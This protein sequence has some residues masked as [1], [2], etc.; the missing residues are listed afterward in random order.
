MAGLFDDLESGAKTGGSAGGG[1]F[2]DLLAPKSEGIVDTLKEGAKSTGRAVGAAVNT[3]TGN[4]QGI[5][6]KALAQQ[7]APKDPRLQ[8]FMQDYSERTAALGD[9]PGVLE[10]IGQGFGAVA[11]NPAGAGLAVVEQLPNAAVALGGGW[12][13][14]KA[15]AA[16]GGALGAAAAGIGAVPGA[17]AGGIIGGIAGMFLGNAALETG[18]KAMGFADDGEVTPEEMSQAK[19]EGAIKGGVI[20]GVDVLTLGIGGKVSSVMQRPTAAAMEA[21]S[22][23]VLID[24]G[25]DVT[26]EAAVLAATKNPTIATAVR[27]AQDNARKA[28][29]KL[30]KRAAVAGTL[31]TMETVGEG[32]GE[33]LGELAATGEGNVPDAVLEGL[34]GLGQSGAEAAWNMARTAPG[35]MVQPSPSA[36]NPAPAPVPAPDPAAGPISRTAAQLPG[37]SI[38]GLLP[39]P[40]QTLYGDA[41]GNL[42]PD[43]QPR[44]VDREYRPTGRERGPQTFGPGM[45]QS[46]PMG[47]PA[48]LEGQL[49][50]G[51]IGAQS[52]AAQRTPNTF[53]NEPS[54]GL[55]APGRAIPD[56]R[57]DNIAVAPDGTAVPGKTPSTPP[58]PYIQ[59]GPGM[60]QQR[61][62]GKTY[63]GLPAAN[64]AIRESVNPD[65]L[66]AV[67]VGPQ[68]FEVRAKQKPAKRVV[69]RDRDSVMQAVIR[70]GGVKT[71][72][73][74]DTTGD[75]KGNKFLPGVGAL[76]SDKT[77]TSLDDMA[78]LLDQSGYVPAGEM[79]RDGGV[80]WLQ[81]ALR[82]EVGGMKTHAAPGSKLQE[83]L[84]IKA[85]ADRLEA[86]AVA[87][88]EEDPDLEARID[89]AFDLN[90]DAAELERRRLASEAWIA[91]LDELFG[92]TPNEQ[93]QPQAGGSA[94][95]DTREAGGPAAGAEPGAGSRDSEQGSGAEAPG[96]TAA[97]GPTETPEVA[98]DDF[99]LQTQTE[100]ELAAADAA[101]KA[102]IKAE[103]KAQAEADEK[104]RK[105]EDRAQI[106]AQSEAQADNFTLGVS[107]EDALSG[108]T[109]MFD[110]QPSL[111]ELGGK[112]AATETPKSEAAPV[113]WFTTRAKAE[114]HLG[115]KRKRET[116]EIV[117]VSP[118]RFEI[119]EKAKSE[120]VAPAAKPATAAPEK[121][122]AS[123]NTI[124]TDE[125]ADE[126]R[127]FIRS[128]LNGSQLNSGVDPRLF[129]AGITLAGYHIE[130]G[131]RTFAAFAKAMLADMGDGV[132]PYLKQWYM[133]V[134]YDPR[135]A[136]LDGMSGAA[137]VDAFNL[138]DITAEA[139]STAATPA[140]AAEPAKSLADHFYQRLT[141]GSLPKDNRELRKLVSDFDGAEADNARLKEA[142]ED[143]EA[144][145]ARRAAD[146]AGKNM[147]DAAT[148]RQLLDLYSA[149]PNLNIRTSSSIENQ[150]YSTP[151][152]LA[153]LAARL[154][155]VDRS[156][157]VY[158]PTAGN[159]MLLLTADPKKA[160][161]N[162]LQDHR[163]ANLTARGFNTI[164]GDALEAL[165]SGALPAKSQDAVIT[166]P[167]FGSVKDD[168]GKPIKVS[169]DGYKI[170]QIDHLIVAE[171]LKAMKDNGKAVL[172]IGANKVQGGVST[173]DRIF[174]NWLYGN[175]NVTSHF[176]VDG[177]LYAR[178]GASWPVRV[179]SINGRAKSSR[180]SPVSGTIQR[181]NTWESV[182]EQ[183][184]EALGAQERGAESVGSAG[185]AVQQPAGNDART[186][187][188]VAGGQGTQA[189]QGS[190]GGASAASDGNVAGAPAG[191]VRNQPAS[192]AS[193][194]AAAT[195]GKRHD[196]GGAESNQ[197]DGR[198]QRQAD[199]QPSS[200]KSVAGTDAGKPAGSPVAD[201]ENSFQTAYVPRSSRKDEGVLVPVNMAD[202]LQNALSALE[203]QVGNIDQFAMRELGYQSVEALHDALMGLQ[204]DS[205]ASAINQIKEN[206]KGIIIADQTG[207]GKG[208]QAAA[209][210]R[211]AARNGYTPVFVTVKPQLFTDM[212][213]DLADIGTN[214]IEPF[215]M[216]SNAA[217]SSPAGDKL[218]ANKASA[219][220]RNLSSIAATGELPDERN[221]LFMTYSQINTENNQR[222][223]LSALAPNAI[224]ILDESHNAS[225]DSKTG[226]YMTS[227]LAQAKGV[228][229]LSATY[230]KRPD[231]MPL[232]F[233]TD[234]GQAISDSSSLI[235]AMAS[236]GLPLQTVI[237]NNLVKA[238]QMFRRERSY[239]GVSISTIVDTESREAHEALSDSVTEALRAIVDADRMFHS[240]TVA[241]M[242]EDAEAA[243][244]A[245]FDNAGNQA[246]ES[247][248]HTQFSSVVHNFVRQM[249]LGLKAN[250]AADRAIEALRR[251]EKPLIALENT[252]GSFLSEYAANN[253]LKQ[254][255]S[256]GD[257]TYR[258]VLSRAL[259]RTLYVIRQDG[260]G[261]K[262]REEVPLSAL[263]PSVRAMYDKAQDIIDRLDINIPVSPL[264][265]IR[266]RIADA[267][268][269]VAEITGRSITVD[270]SKGEPTLSALSAAEQQDKVGT[271]RKFN[272]GE[273]DAIILNVAG[274]T[275]ISLHASE[276]FKDQRK[277][278]MIVAQPAQDIN[279]FMQMLGRVHRTGQVVVPGYELLNVDL[280]TEKRPTALLNGKMKS[281]N[282]NTSSNTESATSIKAADMLNK[283]GDQVIASYLLDN[284]DLMLALDVA[285]KID[286]N[287]KPMDGFARTVTGRMALMPIQVQKD[288][289]AEV[290]EQYATLMEYLNATNQNDLEPRTFDFEA[291]LK[292]D[293]VLVAA[294]DPRTPFGEEA[295]YGEWQIKA[296]GKQMT[297][298]EIRAEMAENLGGKSAGEHAAELSAAA[299]KAYWEGYNEL[300]KAGRVE[301][302]KTVDVAEATAR[303]P[304][305]AGN[306]AVTGGNYFFRQH[307]IGT[308]WR[309]EINGD[310]Y[311]ATITN[312]RNSHKKSGNPFSLSKIQVTLAVNGPLRSLTVPASQ[313]K[314]IEIAPIYGVSI[315]NAYRDQVDGSE[316]AKIITGNLLAAYGEIKDTTGTI[317]SFTKQDGTTEQGILLPKR[318]D[319][320]A[321]TR[322]DYQFRSAA[323]ALKFLNAST[324]PNLARFGIASR[325]GDVRVRPS[326][327][328]I[329]IAVPKSKARGGRYFLDKRLIAITGD[330]VSSNDGMVATVSRNKA[331][332]A[333]NYLM[334]KA[335]LYAL[336]SMAEEA[337]SV[338]GLPPVGGKVESPR[339][340][341]TAGRADQ[342]FVS[343]PTASDYGYET[344]LFGNPVPAPR[345]RAKAARSA[346]AG[347]R[348]DV[349]PASTLSGT[350]TPAGR[351]HVKTIVGT[352]VS[353][354]LGTDRINSFAD[355]AQATQYLY[356]S[357]VERFDGVVTD[358]DG[359]P[360][361][362]VGGFKG[363]ID[364][365][366]VPLAPVIAEAVRVRGAANIWLSHNHPSGV[367]TLSPADRNLHRAFEDA[368]DGSGIEVRGLIAVGRGEYGATD[369]TSG[370]VPAE[371][372]TVSVPVIER[373][374][375][376]EPL[377]VTIESPEAARLV[378]AEYYEEAGRPGMILLDSK[379][380]VTGWAPF[381]PSMTA[382]PLRNTGGLN[383]LYRAVSEGN[384]AAAILVHGGE[385][386]AK[387]SGDHD[388]GM[389]IGA[390]LNKA[391]VR[392][393][394]VVNPKTRHSR[395]QA[396]E[397]IIGRA[398][399]RLSD[400]KTKGIPLFSARAI[401]KKVMAA[402][403]LNA[404]VVNTEADLPA[405]LQAQIK[406]D[407]ATGRVAGVYHNGTAYLVASNL[408]DTKHAISVMLHEA[409]GHG[410]VKSVLG[411]RIG[412]V[413][414]G[415]Y[416][417]MPAAI[418]KELERRYASQI[419]NLS[420][421][422]ANVLIAEEYVAHLAET[423]PQHSVI[424]RLVALLRR[425]IR[426]TFGKSAALKWTRNDLV[427][428]LAEARTA[429]RNGGR[430]PGGAARM[431]ETAAADALAALPEVDAADE[432]AFV[433]SLK[434]DAATRSFANALY[435]A[436]GTES[437]FFKA[438][439]GKS[440]MVDKQGQPIAFVHRSYGERDTFTD[441][442]LGKNTGTP[443]ASLGHF[444]ARKDVGNVERYGPVVEQ[445]YIRMEKPKVITQAQFEAMGDWSLTK[446]QA[447]RKTLMEQG[448]DGL[449]I[450]GLAWPVVFE[451]KN[452][453]ARRNA[454][455]FN[456]TDSARYNLDQQAVER[457]FAETAKAAGGEAAY[458]AAKA[459][460]RTK[461][462]YRQWV[463][464]RT[465]AFKAW[466][467]E[468]EHGT[469][470]GGAGIAGGSGQRGDIRRGAGAAAQAD[471]GVP[472]DTE[473]LRR[474]DSRVRRLDGRGRADSARG[475]HAAPG[476]EA[477]GPVARDWR[478]NPQTGEPAVFHHGTRDAFTAFDLNHPN[479]KDF[480]WL[481]RGAY[482]AGDRR[483]A[484]AYA[485]LK[486]GSGQPRVMDL[487]A[488]VRN[489]FIGGLDTKQE[490]R[491]ANP[492][493][494]DAFT[495]RL[496]AKGH[497][498]VV[499]ELPDGTLELMAFD[500]ANVKSATGNSG[501]FDPSN[502]DIR[503]SLN[504][505]ADT[506]EA[507]R[508]LGLGGRDAD[509]IIE[510]I[511]NMTLGGLKAKLGEWSTRSEEGIFD[512]LAGIKRAEEAVGVTDA[513]SQGYVSARMATGIA[514]VMH[515]VLHYAAPEWRD[516]VI[517]GKANTRGVLEILGDLGQD[518]LTP[519]LAWLGGKRAQMLKAQ[520]RENNLTDAD[521]AE[522]LAMGEG[523][524]ELFEKVYRDYAKTN[525]AVLDLA[526]GAGLIDKEARAKWATEYYVPFYR[527][528]EAEGI[529]TAPRTKRG[530]SHQ[531]AAIKALKGGTLPTNDL[532]TNML[533][534][535]T[536]R[537]D[538]A[539][540]NKALLEVV[541]NLKG[542]E[543]LSD[544]SPRFQ[545]VLIS[546]SQIAQQIRKDRKALAMAADMLG[547]P[548][549]S[550]FLKV[551]NQL[552]KPENEGFEKLWTKVAPTDPDIIRVQRGGK[553]E[554]YR[555]NDESLLR[556]LKFMEGSVF[557]DP[558]TRVGRTF[559]RLLTTGVTAS[560]D[561]ILRNF[562]R[563]AAHAWMINKDGFVLG[564]DSIKGMRD[565][566]REDQDYRDLMFAG[567]SF[568]GGYVHGTDPE[569]SAQII[570]R[571]LEKKGFSKQQQDSY[572]GS[573]VNTPAKAAAMLGRGWQSYRTLGDKVENANRLSTYKAALAAGK[574]KRQAAF[575]AKDLMDYSLRGNFA[576]AQWFTDVVPFLNA[577]LQG[578]YKL[579]RAVK[580]D[581]TLLAKEVAMKGAYIALFSLLLAGIN[582]DDERYQKLMDWDKD[583][584]WHIFLGDQHFRIPKPFE[585]GLIFGTIPERLL[586]ALTGTQDGGD[587]AKAVSNGVFQT[588]AFN[589]VPQFYQPIRELQANRNFFRD[590]PIEDMSDEGKLPEARFDERTSAAGKLLG[591]LTGPTLGISPKQ[592]DHLVQGYTGTLGGY[593]LGMSNLVAGAF[594]DAARPSARAGDLPVVKVLYQGDDVRSTKYQSEFY[595]MMREADQLHR[596]IKAYREEGR[597]DA[598]AQLL[599]SSRDKLRHRAALGMARQQ[600]GAVRKQM[601]AVY[602]DTSMSGEAKRAKLD[603]L[604]VRAN[605]IAERIVSRAG[606]DF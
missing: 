594:D 306:A 316:K 541:D 173:D 54:L 123:S 272:S 81:Q 172:I 332:E 374:Q 271:T 517:A 393:L 578:L 454:G 285:S 475:S 165:A 224:V 217:I 430:G 533:T 484:E 53:D 292:K 131:A 502:P 196:D 509:G 138:A 256:L 211:W 310:V 451:G 251:G 259:A 248:D 377:A 301:G 383:A 158:E 585:L 525:E 3:Y 339:G 317:I 28:T 389:N 602:R 14:M 305:A 453:K 187:Q 79:E 386:D 553:N 350:P 282:A 307:A 107:G 176:E 510:Q 111:S 240:V 218:F 160:T 60:D 183:Y 16:A 432:S 220:K 399:Y 546:R 459:A 337:H 468:W 66:E 550:K 404:T 554:Y 167:P 241:S 253:E 55:P 118:T 433:A 103:E 83:A 604:Q 545:Q 51:G 552:M 265:W 171:S 59:G 57:G 593:V 395:A 523:K 579:G 52:Q 78:S 105:E 530:L 94:D 179:I 309:V 544:E 524:E 449:Y 419:E 65:Q 549:G 206:G 276:K 125:A 394:D 559:K 362:V 364:S 382:G 300:V 164:Q 130:K 561:F 528:D 489:P 17:A 247:V 159:G 565:A 214:D 242:Q 353:R 202:P 296:Q 68:T 500:P 477:E 108:Q 589:P 244:E 442:D 324:D 97:A 129:Q 41:A 456:E 93:G 299:L 140:P 8:K 257:F 148:F 534:G 128:M 61:E 576:A 478:L 102:R 571:A 31:L 601:D 370:S 343:E 329:A 341:Y 318:F 391:G 574:S 112:P 471:A 116:H 27:T 414:A 473:S 527:Q 405:D 514:D 21:A 519:W 175:Y 467:G 121:P 469:E 542:S 427:L 67:K 400:G 71:E 262:V 492:E 408:R 555:V 294:T 474:S 511:R 169:V 485:K 535:W 441:A 286:S 603:Q 269:S 1:M 126:A 547:L 479:R 420:E 425:F 375:V 136:E 7:Q 188:A 261:N 496:R 482:L 249:L 355:L 497:D 221:A 570:R 338:L 347:V 378:A 48:P 447:Y 557:N 207:I 146:I 213:G 13:G 411:D 539:M 119:H 110:S 177:A 373:E 228:V 291:V 538:A 186:A 239:D 434:G 532:L 162:E 215:I 504:D 232:Y 10:T 406:R 357:A 157:S 452:I 245:V 194:T 379:H 336:P 56:M 322:G 413:M 104:R 560:P 298:E 23:K 587:L 326:Y 201:G 15:G 488:N 155:D 197:L 283:Y 29:D 520:G 480:G 290:E 44:N 149:Q 372:N 354:R 297:A 583:M 483:L 153:Y 151:A 384:A 421:A 267:G 403:G 174:F 113:K 191:T 588:L 96:D 466:F 19:S 258:T 139:A 367:A 222:A 75:D 444:L 397:T 63:K 212:Y 376:G 236:G 5:A 72:W 498:G 423:D 446:V 526:E 605:Q 360:L 440:R 303:G 203:D 334:A 584:H 84:S 279:I 410:G 64:R 556:G 82:D 536:K 331:Q 6:D 195:D 321:N 429:A 323:D 327:G 150:A 106:K 200:G 142:Q 76:W 595:D 529:F 450:Q 219:H 199:K 531:T 216:N 182:Y 577:R 281:L 47:E 18:H 361:A 437:P 2:D 77:G 237:A 26:S 426:D 163:F 36:E 88:A 580:G 371:G 90:E 208:R 120:P 461:L 435:K 387:I 260:A 328:D 238:G 333:L 210:I 597:V 98:V 234:I 366:T 349:Q 342:Q 225:G 568:Q 209:M 481:G 227:V 277:R 226:E 37:P 33:Y 147:S 462:N 476:R 439:F 455:T 231:N 491:N 569:A 141:E 30:G 235:E 91:E 293:E 40:G 582:D 233:K 592:L 548:E 114:T 289:Y 458:N 443:T 109:G 392:V 263:S 132:K 436:R 388:S 390:G 460:G 92:D 252:M 315:E 415:I 62:V 401:A 513:N 518:N 254:G 369:N 250:A 38:A 352:E 49:I 145:I 20:T 69:N 137:I 344:D 70:L 101:T 34:L 229:Y 493:Y 25:V 268:Y 598:A 486:R 156:T 448:H 567:G 223:A 181:Y 80:T 417:D 494:I 490:L 278:L 586:H 464:V 515:G 184:N 124:F 358:K 308:M 311:N 591:Q 280:P 11:D 42:S 438:W 499:L 12:A 192:D 503:Y 178:Q 345:G 381:T 412:K 304:G 359:K 152:P 74:R 198:S 185:G 166:N 540:K 521:I 396:G 351:Y 487:F 24:N 134:K 127:A 144:A 463:Q 590:M 100:A 363:A 428:L 320:K 325:A 409:I 117:E 348:G 288:F 522:L 575:E 87:A 274:S 495:R 398:L 314:S 573:L 243:G 264:D 143:L 319:F 190:R 313:W 275:G 416:R 465:P 89:Q 32:L 564:K 422:D 507:L 506:T 46:V 418:R 273:L 180:V 445:F 606:G 431:R 407:K 470:Q 246:S 205:V 600:L 4:G 551:A 193:G 508:K 9:D 356:R 340:S 266:Q 287:G 543:F 562:I 330:F 424:N 537:I 295:V 270:Y 170:G 86:Q 45:D 596:T 230:A 346:G 39:S 99:G 581:K 457:Q 365:A 284:D 505:E 472:G 50:R 402:T 168:S 22:R 204:V 501:N 43:G 58:A 161:A 566:L 35:R 312:L 255:D 563:D 302:G 572:L 115:M 335:P 154:A 380:R 133:G 85:E 189:V 512:G 135:A 95:S 516:G 385:L 558:I 599:E 368:F 122:A 73:R